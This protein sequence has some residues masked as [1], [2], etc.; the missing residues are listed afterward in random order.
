MEVVQLHVASA[1]ARNRRISIEAISEEQLFLAHVRSVRLRFEIENSDQRS[2]R[3]VFSRN[4][5]SSRHPRGALPLLQR[6]TRPMR[7]TKRPTPLPL[8][9]RRGQ[10]SSGRIASGGED[11]LRLPR[12]ESQLVLG[13]AS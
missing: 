2:L 8:V 7:E 9:F 6:R 1:T 3:H 10:E 4:L 12:C 5:T 11:R 13:I